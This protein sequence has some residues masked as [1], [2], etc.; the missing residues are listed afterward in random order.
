MRLLRYIVTLAAV[1]AVGACSG[2]GNKIPYGTNGGEDG[3]ADIKAGEALG[4]D[5]ALP[6]EVTPLK[7]AV[8]P[9]DVIAD[10]APDLPEEELPAPDTIP[11]PPGCCY[12]AADC[13]DDTLACI[14]AG[15]AT[16]Q[17]LCVT[18]PDKGMCWSDGDC[19]GGQSCSGWVICGCGDTCWPEPGICG[20]AWPPEGCC[21][22]DSDC[23]GG[24]VCAAS[25]L[26]EEPGTCH[27]PL[28][29]GECFQH[30]HCGPD[31]Y[32]IGTNVSSCF[33]DFPPVAGQ[34]QAFPEWCCL[35]DADCDEGFVC[36]GMEGPE[37]PGSCEFAPGPG[38]CYHDQHCSP[39][40]QCVGAGTCPCVMDCAWVGP[41]KCE[42]LMP[43]C[44][45]D[46]SDCPDLD[47]GVELVCIGGDM[48]AGGVC[49]PQPKGGDCFYYDDCGNDQFCWGA[50]VCSCDMNCISEVGECLYYP[51]GCCWSDQDCDGGQVC[52]GISPYEGMGVC[53]GPAGPGKC[54]T[55]QQ[56]GPGQLCSG[57]SVCPCDADCDM[58]DTPGQCVPDPGFGC[59]DDSSDC[60][61]LDNGPEMVC[62][63]TD[64][65]PGMVGS[66]Q[67]AADFGDCWSDDD[68][69]E[70]QECTGMTYCPCGVICGVGT[71]PGKCSPLPGG[72]CYD[73]SDCGN[74]EVCKG[75]W[76]GDLM[77]GSC[78]P[79]PN[80]GACPFD[81][82]CCW[83][84]SDCGS[85]SSGC[86]NASVCGCIELC[87]VCG[88]CMP[89]QMGY[90][91]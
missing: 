56:C 68:C 38:E 72:C 71:F 34:C 46:D 54:W 27:P 13:E 45:K 65:A 14:Y 61:D 21:F 42:P 74:D 31:E 22:T 51:G 91:D 87:W 81:A 30:E 60:P 49:L 59:C 36:Q 48:G 82:Q 63:G 7:D 29:Y 69:Y 16:D 73:D 2:A 41:G 35:S 83:D 32:C 39:D 17:G 77:P 3:G 79:D 78:V 57:V 58:P 40:E 23:E 28:S 12:S 11:V 64:V 20:P 43:F 19:E 10:A 62:V 37:L 90:C 33:D 6:E 85:G 75:V 53:E 26:F 52:A 5:A 86:Q 89:D 67:P 47:S 8:E 70:T 4:E 15:P 66:C 44:C 18:A 9:E 24:A 25:P 76:G 80:G 55:D 1:V 84:N 88:D 50:D